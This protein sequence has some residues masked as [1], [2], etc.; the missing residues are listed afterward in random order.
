MN[1]FDTDVLINSYVNQHRSKHLYS[2]DLIALKVET[3]SFIISWLTVQ[4]VG[5][6]LGK[7]KQDNSYIITKLAQ[8]IDTIPAPYGSIEFNRAIELATLVGFTDFNDCLHTAI[9]EQSCTDFY[10][11]NK[12]DFTR[13]QPH[14]DLIIHILE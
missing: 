11:Y 13:I 7:L 2:I 1:Y 12:N 5:F 9:A 3:D 6:V 14:T 8:L 10:T 4:E